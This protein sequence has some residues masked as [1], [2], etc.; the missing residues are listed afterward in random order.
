MQRNQTNKKNEP[1]EGVYRSDKDTEEA[2]N[3]TEEKIKEWEQVNK[4]K[5]SI[6]TSNYLNAY[7][8]SVC[9]FYFFYLFFCIFL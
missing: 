3:L 8:T 5:G 1:I 4:G 6:F 2:L 7:T 9:L